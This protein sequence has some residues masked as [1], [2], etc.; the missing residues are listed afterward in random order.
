MKQIPIPPNSTQIANATQT[1]VH[2]STVLPDTT[3]TWTPSAKCYH[4]TAQSLTPQDYAL[5]ALQVGKY[6]TEHA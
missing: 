1:T 5:P 4:K 6:K 2:A 3:W